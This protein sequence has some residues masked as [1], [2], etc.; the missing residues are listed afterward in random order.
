[1]WTLVQCAGLW[2]F[3]R[4]FKHFGLYIMI[5]QFSHC[6]AL[7]PSLYSLVWDIKY[8]GLHRALEV[9]HRLSPQVSADIGIQAR[10]SLCPATHW[11][12]WAHLLLKSPC[13][14]IAHAQV[15]WLLT[16]HLWHLMSHGAS[17]WMCPGSYLDSGLWPCL[18]SICLVIPRADPTVPP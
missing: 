6:M 18:R 5:D 13:Q 9:L 16:A 14:T 4:S 7:L 11:W 12:T 2:L 17:F 3:C 8:M 1:M 15:H 10:P